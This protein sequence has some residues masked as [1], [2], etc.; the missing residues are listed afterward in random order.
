VLHLLVLDYCAEPGSLPSSGV[1]PAVRLD[2]LGRGPLGTGR[3]MRGT[4]DRSLWSAARR[5]GGTYS[6]LRLR[7]PLSRDRRVWLFTYPLINRDKPRAVNDV[8][9]DDKCAETG[10]GILGEIQ[11]AVGWNANGIPS[12][13]SPAPMVMTRQA[14]NRAGRIVTRLSWCRRAVFPPSSLAAYAHG[15]VQ[16]GSARIR[17]RS[18]QR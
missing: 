15:P 9:I 6:P 13:R 17:A 14:V 11:V 4:G 10:F 8:L 5:G 7:K 3:E 12:I 2:L 1:R 16:A 18:V